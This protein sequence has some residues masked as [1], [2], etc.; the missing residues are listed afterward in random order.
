LKEVDVVD[1]LK[2]IQ[3]GDVLFQEVVSLPVGASK[4][5]N[6]GQII[7]ARGE[8]TGHRH[9][10]ISDQAETWSFTSNGVTELYLEVQAPVTIQHDEHKSL[11]IP[12]GIYRVGRV[13]EYDYFSQ[14][15][16]QVQD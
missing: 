4:M 7:V 9:V 8:Q 11:S 14:M 10:I 1:K 16:R 13:K 15:E 3:Q 5:P 6:A 12:T 2:Q